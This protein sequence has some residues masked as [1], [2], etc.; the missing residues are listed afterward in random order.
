MTAVS[1]NEIRDKMAPDVGHRYVLSYFFLR[2][3]SWIVSFHVLV[4]LR[5]HP[6]AVTVLSMASGVTAA[7][8]AVSGYFLAAAVFILIWALLD[9][10][11]GEVARFTGRQSKVGQVLEGLNSDLQ[12][13]LWLPAIAAGLHL[14]GALTFGWVVAAFFGAAGFNVV[15]KFFA[16]YPVSVLG[17]PHTPLRLMVASQFKNSADYR[18]RSVSGRVVFIAWRNLLTQFGIFEAL[19]FLLALGPQIGWFGDYLHYFTWFYASAYLTL[20]TVTLAAVAGAGLIRTERTG[21]P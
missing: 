1:I 16:V 6:N 17:D 20:A 12:Y 4:P 14:T 13:A 2:H 15:R 11:D 7:A 10:C 3:I 21:D 8:F 5:L 18:R 19:F 9:C